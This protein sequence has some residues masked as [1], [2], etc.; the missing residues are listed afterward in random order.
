[1]MHVPGTPDLTWLDAVDPAFLQRHDRPGPRYT[2]YP[3][4]PVWTDAVGEDVHRQHLRMVGAGEG[5]VAVYVHVP[6][7]E[8]RCTF[9]GCNVVVT[10]SRERADAYLDAIEREVAMTVE[11][12]RAGAGSD[13]DVRPV[14]QLH[15]GGGTPTFLTIPQLERL[16]GILTAAFPIADGAELSV[17]IDPAVTTREQL[18]CLRRLGMNRVSLGVQDLDDHVLELV[19]RPQTEAGIREVVAW[20]REL[21]FGGVNLDLIYG[22]PGQ[23]ADSFR[24]TLERIHA[25]APDRLAVYSYAHVPW[26]KGHQR[27]IDEETLPSTEEKLRIYLATI[28]FFLEHG[29][30]QVGMDHFAVPHDELAVARRQG[31]LSRNFMGYTVLPSDDM[32]AFGVSAIANVAGAFVQSTP[33]LKRYQEE[34][35]AGRFPVV[36]GHVTSADDRLRADV[37]RGLLCN[38]EL[39]VPA[40]EARHGVDFE[41]TFASALAE[42]APAIEAG[43]LSVIRERDRLVR[44]EVVGA[45]RLLIRNLGMAFDVYLPSAPSSN[46]V[47]SRTV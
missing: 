41:A 15:L 2:S 13:R 7:C 5:P 19:N 31:R 44:L 22:L 21:G 16:L 43:W 14:A 30:E 18:A 27:R 40:V 29:Y 28:R 10:K 37:I 39:D 35:H 20:C 6:F 47:Y 12:L 34:I 46:P 1:M 9:C 11:E 23:T 33:V 24:R 17:E 3:P 36:R 45:G 25:M 26:V 4:V 38:F 32:L 8:E 42:L